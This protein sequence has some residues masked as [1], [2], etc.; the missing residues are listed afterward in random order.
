MSPMPISVH[1]IDPDKVKTQIEALQQHLRPTT[2]FYRGTLHESVLQIWKHLFP[3]ATLLIC[4]ADEERD[5]ESLACA[6]P[7]GTKTSWL[8]QQANSHKVMRTFV[9]QHTVP[10]TALREALPTATLRY[11]LRQY[12]PVP[13]DHVGHTQYLFRGITNEGRVTLEQEVTRRSSI[14]DHKN[15]LFEC[16]SAS[17][18]APTETLAH[19]WKEAHIA[20]FSSR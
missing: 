20:S 19:V 7:L 2:I 5:I 14:C 10:A 9:E 11:R 6:L 17:S 4:C 13:S 18:S 15:I 12:A 1:T 3:T 8:D 16:V